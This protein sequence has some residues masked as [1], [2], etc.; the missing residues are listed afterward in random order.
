MVHNIK[1]SLNVERSQF[2]RQ[3]NFY[4]HLFGHEPNRLDYEVYPDAQREDIDL[5][6]TNREGKQLTISEKYRPVD[7]GDILF[8]IWS[9]YPNKHGWGMD[10][11]ADILTYWTPFRLFVIDM[12]SVVT[13]FNRNRVSEKISLING[14]MEDNELE[15]DGVTYNIKVIRALNTTYSSLSV[16]IDTQNLTQMGIRYGLIPLV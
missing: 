6:I 13:L 2:E 10:S 3:D 8:E 12:P 7:Y 9:V 16:A 11:K 1:D 4:R 5:T 14:V 15:L